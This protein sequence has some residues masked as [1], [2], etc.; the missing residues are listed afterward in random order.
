MSSQGKGYTDAPAVVL[1]A[2]ANNAAGATVSLMPFGISGS[3]ITTYQQRVWV[4][5]PHGTAFTVEPPGGDFMVSAPGSYVD[6]ATS[7]GGV[8]FTNSDGFL[9]VKYTGIH[10]SNGYLYLLADGSVSIVSSVNTSG[11]PATTTFNYQNVDPQV[12]ALFPNSVQDMGKTILF[13]NEVGV[14]GI[15]GGSATLASAKLTEIFQ[16]INYTTGLTPT[17]AVAT[18]FDVKHYLLLATVTDPDTGIPRNVMLTWNEKEWTITSQTVSLTFINSQ[19]R[20]S[21]LYAWGTNGSTIY[22]LFATPST[23]LVKR[24][25]T[26]MYGGGPNGFVIKDMTYQFM[27]AQDKSA[28]AAGVT[29]AVTLV[30]SGMTPQPNDPEL[31]TV[32]NISLAG[33]FYYNG[34]FAAPSPYWPSFGTR[35]TGVS[36]FTIGARLTTT[37]PDFILADWRFAYQDVGALM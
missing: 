9:Q 1:G 32:P 6:F 2:G 28:N 36:F 37:S 14:Y 35:T 8:L 17:S 27:Q 30:A 16:T 4:A 18:L 26:K 22:P 12:G 25:D 34:T 15:Y 31:T 11:N 10:Q 5:N 29:C 3:S 24:L 19:K 33:P 23:T 13:A 20:G 21:K 7:S